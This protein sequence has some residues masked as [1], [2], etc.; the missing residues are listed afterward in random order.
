MNGLTQLE[1]QLVPVSERR[2]LWGVG[3]LLGGLTIDKESYCRVK[4]GE[5]SSGI[6]SQF[7]SQFQI[8]DPLVPIESE[9]PIVFYGVPNFSVVCGW[10]SPEIVTPE[11]SVAY[12]GIFSDD[13]SDYYISGEYETLAATHNKLTVRNNLTVGPRFLKHCPE[14]ITLLEPHWGDLV[15]SCA[16]SILGLSKMPILEPLKR[17]YVISDA[18]KV[19]K[20][21]EEHKLRG[22]LA[23]AA[24]P[25]NQ[26]F[27]ETSVKTLTILEDGEG[28]RTLFC[29][30]KFPGSLDDAMHAL[31]NFDHNWW[32]PNARKFGAR[33]NFDFE[34]V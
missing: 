16:N 22:I 32:L 1:D 9:P 20:F 13:P 14:K 18:E 10:S 30:V 23:R 25:I 5:P 4:F 28:S 31:D 24:E 21:V 2:C 8:A 26:A 7:H 11:S 6:R 15:F 19:A 33:L 3:T 12:E 27:G 34:L 17:D 29:Y